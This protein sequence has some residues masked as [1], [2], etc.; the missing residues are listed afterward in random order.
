MNKLK[1][2]AIILVVLVHLFFLLLLVT[3]EVPYIR[4]R[5]TMYG[6]VLTVAVAL[7]LWWLV[8]SYLRHK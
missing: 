5:E 1:T 4:D 8:S 7:F 6:V 2:I 3:G